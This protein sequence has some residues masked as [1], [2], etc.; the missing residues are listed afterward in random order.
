LITTS[1]FSG[2]SSAAVRYASA[3]F[4]PANVFSP[5]VVRNITWAPA[6]WLAEK[7]RV[8]TTADGENTGEVLVSLNGDSFQGV[9]N[10]EVCRPS[11][12]EYYPKWGLYRGVSTSSGFS[13]NDYVQHSNVTCGPASS[14]PQASAPSFSP[15]AGTYASA[16]NVT[17]TSS[18]SGASIRYTTDG[19]TPS[20][21][22][23]TLYSG[24][25]NISKSATL[26]AIAYEVGFADSAIA[27]GA[28]TIGS[29]QTLNFEA[30]S[31]SFT[32]SGATTSVQTDSNSSGGKWVE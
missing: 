1:I 8:T 10:V 12:T 2:T 13:P 26:K 15:A 27:S 14:T 30:E 11:S 18:T 17:I 22:A 28:Y 24:P 31:L 16:Q 21:T 23:G 9:T 19:S 25:V 4:S 5:K 29:P 7:I 3:S 20:E 32:G 6:T